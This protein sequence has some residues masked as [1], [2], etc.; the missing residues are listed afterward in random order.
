MKQKNGHF[1]E[2]ISQNTRQSGL[3]RVS[4]IASLPSAKLLALGKV[5]LSGT[6]LMATLPSVFPYALGKVAN[7]FLFHFFLFFD[8]NTTEIYLNTWTLQAVIIKNI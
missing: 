4:R 3:H 5:A 2:C 7:F 8:T 1:A 6:P